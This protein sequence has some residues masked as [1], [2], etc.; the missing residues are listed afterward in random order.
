MLDLQKTYCLNTE[1]SVQLSI[2]AQVDEK[3]INETLTKDGAK[4]GDYECQKIFKG[5]AI[6]TYHAEHQLQEYK[7]PPP[8]QVYFM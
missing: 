7:E 2:K 3:T 6:T 8:S 1:P 4:I 5:K